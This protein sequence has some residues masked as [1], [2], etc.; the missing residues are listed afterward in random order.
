M[1]KAF[2]LGGTKF[3]RLEKSFRKLKQDSI[4]LEAGSG[5]TLVLATFVL[6]A[7][8]PLIILVGFYFFTHGEMSL[9]VYILFLLL[10]TKMCEPLMQALMFLGLA[11]YMGL[12]VE[13][14]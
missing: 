12:S 1:I 6:N 4:R 5:P 8:I 14:I 9:P 13:R 11:T 10:G 3:E 2:N 7:S